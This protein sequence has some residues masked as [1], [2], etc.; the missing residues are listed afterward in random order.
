MMICR[1][2]FH[3]YVFVVSKMVKRLNYFYLY[4]YEYI[5]IYIF[6]HSQVHFIGIYLKAAAVAECI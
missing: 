2:N 3:G 4:M 5:H 6:A 1:L